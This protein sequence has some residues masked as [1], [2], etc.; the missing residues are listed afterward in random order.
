[1]TCTEILIKF[2]KSLGYDEGHDK[3]Y[4]EMP[5]RD[6]IAGVRRLEKEGEKQLTQDEW[7]EHNC[8]PCI[9]VGVKEIDG[10]NYVYDQDKDEWVRLRR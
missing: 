10:R 9:H 2:L 4:V 5:I 8:K 3:D 7:I 6:L 1:M